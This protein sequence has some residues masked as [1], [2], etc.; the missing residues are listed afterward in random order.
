MYKIFLFVTALTLHYF[1]SKAQK[2]KSFPF[3]IEG[4]INAD[5]G[6]VK[7]TPVANH[8]YYSNAA[9]TFN[10]QV[11][12]K[13]F[14]IEG[15]LDYPSGY[16]L[17]YSNGF[18]TGRFILEKGSQSIKVNL[19]SNDQ[20]P[21][22]DNSIMK[23]DYEE[24]KAFHAEFDHKRDSLYKLWDSLMVKFNKN[25][26][27]EMKAREEKALNESYKEND[28]LLLAYV[29]SHP[30]SY[31]AFWKL[32]FL[33]NFGYENIFDSIFHNFSQSIKTTHAAK[34][35]S[36][37][38]ITSGKLGIGKAFPL[39]PMINIKNEK[40]ETAA[41][42][43]NRYTLIDFWY[44]NCGPCRAQTPDLKAMYKLYHSKGFEIIG[45]STDKVKYKKDWL[46]VIKKDGL[47]WPQFW[48]IDG[49]EA[50]NLSIEAFP[51]NFL[52]DS[53]GKIIRK[54]M[55]TSELQQFLSEQM[56]D[57]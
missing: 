4:T 7:L 6:T 53:K 14:M 8:E 21:Q 51:T 34:I 29:S 55:R 43:R 47:I 15:H 52:L 54:N 33:M 1:S 36:K 41:L 10:G 57:F 37:N 30:D 13:K 25:I 50:T 5:S 45:V 28:R 16:S 42:L 23:K 31:F 32:V 3:K 9:T 18:R 26:P 24:F 20:M 40:F 12:N 2:T 35:L 17:S 39:I 11:K 27:K 38:L 48:D 46:E 19:D 49:K 44:H 22:V 56:K